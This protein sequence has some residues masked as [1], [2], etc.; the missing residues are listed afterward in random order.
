VIPADAGNRK[1]V[2]L[3]VLGGI[4]LHSGDVELGQVLVQPKRFALLA[5]LALR[6]PG[7]FLRRDE[8]LGAFWADSTEDRARAALRQAL[9]F[10]RRHLGEGVIVNR[11]NAEVGIAAE[12]VRC[13]AL[14]FLQALE[15]GRD[16][17]AVERYG[18]ELL[19]GFLLDGVWEFDRWLQAER[20]RLRVAAAE[21][22]LRLGDDAEQ[23]GDLGR[24]AERVRWALRLEPTNETVGRRLISLLARSGNRPG[25]VEAYEALATRLARD[26]DLEPSPETVELLAAVQAQEGDGSASP[27]AGSAALVAGAPGPPPPSPQRVLVLQMENLTGDP[28]LDTLGRLTADAVAQGL[29]TIPELEVLPPMAGGGSPPSAGEAPAELVELA[30]PMG[31]GTVV[32][33]AIHLEGDRLRFQVRFTDVAGGKL[34][35]GPE[36]VDTHRSR[37]LEGVEELRERIMTSLGPALTRRAVHVREAARP[38]GMEAY[39]EYMAGLERFIRREWRSALVHFRRSATLEPDYALPRVVSAIAL[40]NLGELDEAETAASE[41]AGLSQSLGRFE[42]AVLAMVLA[43]LKGDWAAAHQAAGEQADLAPGS[44]PHFQV[45]EE[46]RRLN[47]PRQARE[48]LGRLDP[49]A[50]EMRGWIFYWIELTQAHHLVGDHARELEAASRCRRA[51][52]DDPVAALLEIRALAGLGRSSDVIR[53]VEQT[54]ASPATQAPLPGELLV[55]AALEL[56]A[57]ARPEPDARDASEAAEALLGQAVAWYREKIREAES[58][59]LRRELGR[60]LYH[61]GQ[62]DEAET[63][64]DELA[65]SSEG[66]VQPIGYHHGHLQAHLDEGYLAV[67]AARRGDAEDVDR[68]CSRLERLDR[69]FLY[70]AQWFW[71]AAVSALLDDRDRAVRMLRRA[72]AGGLPM[73]LFIHTDPHLARLRGYGPFDALMRPRR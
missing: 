55:E 9:R 27:A 21:A 4:G 38:P 40:W 71:L 34:L 44:I 24:A 49:D 6:R 45:A 66:G 29:A 56:R 62:Y 65:R 35:R 17:A 50:G 19:P 39:R 69:P 67:I 42:R 16:E 11:G 15:L 37:P 3:D 58:E 8:L 20:Q 36:P 53:V 61:A 22:A 2:R 18:G 70:G 47:R 64:F 14:A 63:V 25:A 32:G 13:D 73:E 23:E 7:G 41:A 31:A 5:Y 26:F 52:P 60:A 48:V 30:Q 46:A 10:L 59:S 57:H 68:R 28:A 72:F 51:H 33:G 43:W 12:A 54:L 1:P